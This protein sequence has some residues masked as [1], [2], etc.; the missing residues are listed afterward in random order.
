MEIVSLIFEINQQLNNM[1]LTILLITLIVLA[2]SFVVFLGVQA[3]KITNAYLD[4]INYGDA[5]ANKPTFIRINDDEDNDYVFNTNDICLITAVN[6]LNREN[7]K[8]L[9][10]FCLKDNIDITFKYDDKYDRDKIYFALSDYDIF[11]KVNLNE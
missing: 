3:K 6:D 8:Y 4:S 2:V 1:G 7:N 10:Q 11:D 5:D 9:L